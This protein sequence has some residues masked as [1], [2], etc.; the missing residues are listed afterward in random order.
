MTIN[1]GDA[2]KITAQGLTVTGE[3]LTANDYKEDGG[4]Y[5]ELLDAKGKYYYWKQGID[6]GTLLEVNG[7]KL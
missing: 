1:Q 7:Q 2:V 5:I 4:W 3:V 6:G